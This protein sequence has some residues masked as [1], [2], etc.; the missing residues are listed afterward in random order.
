MAKNR[1]LPI[2]SVVPTGS[3][4]D[5]PRFLISDARDR[6]WNG[7]DFGPTGVLYADPNAAATEVQNILRSHFEG[8]V[9]QRYQ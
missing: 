6:L 3:S 4:D 2:L 5:F 8:V 1:K 9:P 7:H